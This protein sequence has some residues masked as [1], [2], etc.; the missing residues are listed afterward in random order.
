M[1]G[2]VP[3]Y[4]YASTDEI[5]KECAKELGRSESFRKVNVGVFFGKPGE[6]VTDPYFDGKG[7][8]RNGC[9]LCGGCMVGCRYN[10]K[11]TLDKNY[12][13]LAEKLGAQISAEKEVLNIKQDTEGYTLTYKKSTGL[14]R[15]KNSIKA[16]KII[17]SGGVMGSVKLLLKCKEKQY[18]PNLSKCLGEYVRTNSESIL[19]IRSQTID[20]N[21]DFTKGIAISSGF[22]PDS[23]THIETCRYGVGQNSMSMLTTPI[24]NK[25]NII[26]VPIR[27][28]FNI[29]LHPVRFIRDSIPYKWSSQTVILLIMQPVSNYLKL[30]YKRRWWRLWGK[31]MNSELSSGE[32]IPSSIPMGEQVANDIA[33]DINGVPMSTYMDTFFGIPTTAHIL[34]GAAMGDSDQS[35]VVNK[36]F[37]VYNYPGLYVIDGSVVPSNLGVN[38]SLT[39]TALAEYAMSKFPQKEI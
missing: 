3:S 18:L 17:F 14:L 7:P 31:S 34:G 28:I 25:N 23:T 39:I 27:W 33:N 2:T 38:P 6:E 32:P 37:E 16:K 12:L 29:I 13:Y 15:Y 4:G 19:G 5:L 26:P 30:S 8:D 11:N 9:T 21:K 1:L 20:K 35:G 36:N 10:A 22:M 24:F